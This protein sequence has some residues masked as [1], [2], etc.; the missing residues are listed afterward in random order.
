MRSGARLLLR[1]GPAASAVGTPSGCSIHSLTL[2]PASVR[3]AAREVRAAAS[4][5]S[6]T[7]WGGGKQMMIYF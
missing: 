3:A 4:G 5:A 6:R 2:A 1:A 7:T